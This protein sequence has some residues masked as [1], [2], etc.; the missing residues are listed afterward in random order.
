MYVQITFFFPFF[1]DSYILLFSQAQRRL[2][3]QST[4]SNVPSG[5]EVTAGIAEEE[6]EE[7][8]DLEEI[9]IDDENFT[10]TQR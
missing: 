3:A 6:E 10:S 5:P 8:G 7:E 2:A 1:H 9:E 4:G